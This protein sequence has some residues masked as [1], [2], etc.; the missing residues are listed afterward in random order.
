MP[1]HSTA[2]STPSP[3][4]GATTLLPAPVTGATMTQAQTTAPSAQPTRGAGVESKTTVLLTESLNQDSAGL[5]TAP[6]MLATSY[7]LYL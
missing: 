3:L 7:T 2:R 1:R 5:T 6:V 4:Q